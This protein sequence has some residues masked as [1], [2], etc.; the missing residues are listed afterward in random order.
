[1]SLNDS[2]STP[3]HR[4]KHADQEKRAVALSSVFA[5]FLL[6]VMKLVVGLM[7]GSLGILSEAAHSGAGLRGGRR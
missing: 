1:M 5:G 2:G 3:V 6:T 7:T 4:T